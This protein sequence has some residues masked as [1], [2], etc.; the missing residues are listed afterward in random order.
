MRS[1]RGQRGFTLVEVMIVVAIIGILAAVAVPNFLSW[2]PNIRLK[3]A[4]RDLY[5][6]LM[7][8]KGEAVKRNVNCAITFNQ[9][10]A[11]TPFAYIVYVDAD[12][13]C[14]FDPGPVPPAETIIVRMQ[15]WPQD[16]VLDTSQGGGDGLSFTDN[17]DGNPTIVFRQNAIPTA[18]G[19]GITNGTAFLRSS[20][21]RSRGVVV[22]QAGNISIN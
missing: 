17:D 4:A 1:K 9:Q 18:N 10:V 3:A 11:G 15:Q 14:E 19:G 21:G 13:D 5:S 8:A 20:S 12:M 16:V 7:Q 2:L 6:D 22:N